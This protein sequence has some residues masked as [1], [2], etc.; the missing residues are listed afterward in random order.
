[1]LPSPLEL[2]SRTASSLV[3][4]ANG[5]LIA[6]VTPAALYFSELSPPTILPAGLGGPLIDKA[7]I[8]LTANN[9]DW[10]TWNR[11]GEATKTARVLRSEREAKPSGVA[12]AEMKSGNG[13]IVVSNIPV[14]PQT[15]QAATLNRMLLA[16]LGV[17]LGEGAAQRN[18]LGTGGVL[19]GAL[20]AGRYDLPT[21]DEATASSFVA[22]NGGPSFVLGAVAKDNRTWTPVTTG[23][24]GNFDFGAL[25]AINAQKFSFTYLSFWLYSPKDL[26]NL[27]LD[28]HLPTLDLV[29]GASAATQVWINSKPVTTSTQGNQTIAA[30]LPLQQGWNHVL[31]KAVRAPGDNSGPALKLQS[32]QA[33]YLAQLRAAQEKS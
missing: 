21:L 28:P 1:L 15:S 22:P 27:L 31:V 26:T 18:L 14:A 12:L 30:A 33:D 5:G 29:S 16:N 19:T 17:A 9:V 25:R 8:L 11:Q 6:G 2:T 13:R 32:S 4:V 20:A 3:P 7:Q 23:A 24:D 10:T